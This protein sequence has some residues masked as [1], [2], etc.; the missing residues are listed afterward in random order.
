MVSSAVSSRLALL[1]VPKSS[2]NELPS[3]GIT[4]GLDGV[5]EPIDVVKS[6]AGHAQQVDDCQSCVGRVG[7][8]PPLKW[9]LPG[10]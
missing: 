8:L 3:T 10:R 7:Q 9:S 1:S 6:A 4:A 2:V 5:E